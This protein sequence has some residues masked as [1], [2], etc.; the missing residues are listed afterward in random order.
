METFSQRFFRNLFSREETKSF[1]FL[2]IVGGVIF[3]L[4]SLGLFLLI[5]NAVLKS[6][7]VFLDNSISYYV[8]SLRTGW[9]TAVMRFFT[10][11]GSQGLIAGWVLVII[12]LTRRKHQ[13]KM[14]IFTILLLM[15]YAADSWLKLLFKVPRPDISV[16]TQISVFINADLYSYPSG[17]AM[18]SFLFYGAVSYFIFH[19]TKDKKLSFQISIVS[20]AVIFLVGLSRIYLGVHRPSDVAAGYVAGF[21]LLVTTIVVDKTITFFRLIRESK[22]T[23]T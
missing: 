11:L 18:N 21:W 9:L 1:V 15:G 22:N 13:K 16:L 14:F 8:Y 4:I 12:F 6:Q 5:S 23:A 17:H 10:F 3:S 7:T 20:L 2:E 19:L